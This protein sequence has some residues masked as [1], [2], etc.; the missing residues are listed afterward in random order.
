MQS[1]WEHQIKQRWLG[2]G[3]EILGPQGND[4]HKTNVPS[5]RM[6]YRFQTLGE[7]RLMVL[8]SLR[9]EERVEN[10]DG[11]GFGSLPGEPLLEHVKRSKPEYFLPSPKMKPKGFEMEV[12]EMTPLT[13]S[14]LVDGNVNMIRSGSAGVSMLAERL[15]KGRITSLLDHG[16]EGEEDFDDDIWE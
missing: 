8:S 1:G 11:E 16:F 14:A 7:E 9:K 5:I 13:E 6:T 15:A 3:Y 4:I 2:E 12:S 10:G